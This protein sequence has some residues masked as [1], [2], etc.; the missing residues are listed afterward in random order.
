MDTRVVSASWLLR[1]MSVAHRYLLETLLSVPLG[2][3]P[4][5]GAGS[6]GCSIF[7]LLRNTIE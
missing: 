6:Q 1:I 2:V 7:S 5:M 3:Y 4:D